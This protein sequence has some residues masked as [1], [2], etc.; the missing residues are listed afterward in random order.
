MV[1]LELMLKSMRR[2]LGGSEG[3]SRLEEMAF[4]SRHAS[5]S[6]KFVSFVACVQNAEVEEEKKTNSKKRLK[7]NRFD[8]S[9]R[10]GRFVCSVLS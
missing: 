8:A 5:W 4:E 3:G 6:R 1:I 7:N 10:A 2:F 9:L